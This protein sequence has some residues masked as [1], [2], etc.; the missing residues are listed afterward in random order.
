M[1]KVRRTKRFKRKRER[2]HLIRN[3]PIK[4]SFMLYVISCAI[5]AVVLIMFEFVFF[6]TLMDDLWREYE[7][8]STQIEHYYSTYD[9]SIIY[10]YTVLESDLVMIYDEYIQKYEL[11][12]MLQVLFVPVLS[13]LCIMATGI[14]FYNRKLR[15]PLGL[16]ED[17]SGKIA[18]GD[19]DFQLTYDRQ[20]EMGR[21]VTSFEIM[22]RALVS[23]NKEMWRKVDQRKCLNAAFAHDLRTPLTVLRGYVEYLQT[24]VPQGRVTE[25]KIASTTDVMH[26]Y[27]TR[28][29][30][31]TTSMSMVQKLEEAEMKPEFI[32]FDL[33]TQRLKSTADILCRANTLHFTAQGSGTVWT[34][35]DIV[36]QVLENLVSNASRYAKTAIRVHC[37][38]NQDHFLELIVSDDGEGF[39]DALLQKG[40]APYS[41]LNDN[42]IHSQ[43][44]GLGLYICK[45]LCT[46]HGGDLTIENDGGAKVVATFEG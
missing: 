37:H 29:E 12:N 14:L 39:P 43:H 11:Y 28:L 23:N 5:V 30:G 13:F 4:W 38:I 21:L 8:Y 17:A 18:A 25:E 36:S 15:E 1:E 41:R 33:L 9:S 40:I 6:S 10:S 27:V 24:Y 26:A 34:D 19:L 32:D 42:D 20:N 16:I 31:Y 22:R 46:S 2:K 35:I 45:T 44:Y 7:P 3:L